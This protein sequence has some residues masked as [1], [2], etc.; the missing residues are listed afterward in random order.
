MDVLSDVLDT[1][2]VDS[3][4]LFQTELT[5][6]WGIHAGSREHLAFHVVTRGR[7]WLTVDGVA[8]PLVVE[9]GDVVVLAPWRDHTLRDAPDT[10]ARDI[11][12]L[13]AAGAFCPIGASSVSD[14]AGTTQLVCGW[15]RFSDAR[16]EVLLSALPIV[17]HAREQTT[18]AGLWLAQTVK[19][20]SYESRGVRPGM[21]T[22]INRLCDALFVY[23]LRSHLATLP[24]EEPSWL[25]ALVDPQ[26]GVALQLVHDDPAAPWSVGKLAA[27]VGMSRSAFSA[28]FTKVV[29]EPPMQYL[30]RWRLRK[31]SAMLRDG[32]LDIT[33][34]AS[35]SGYASAA[36]FGKAFTREHGVAPG[37]YRRAVRS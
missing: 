4:M 7:C 33:L 25:R 18:D 29:G 3:G 34:I 10:P 8:E 30:A 2:R 13:V 15:F 27:G 12:D 6:P 36:A 9:T 16:S 20:L 28:H 26:I 17:L 23:V 5:A 31:A 1:A 21:T 37:A 19:M 11:E 32:D 22:V 35:R 14:A 24:A